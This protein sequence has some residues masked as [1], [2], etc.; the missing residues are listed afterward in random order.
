ME[1]GDMV[2]KATKTKGRPEAAAEEVVPP[3]KTQLILRLVR[4]KERGKVL[5]EMMDLCAESLKGVDIGVSK[6]TK[7]LAAMGL[8]RRIPPAKG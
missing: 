3:T 4:L 6:T 7:M 8:K 5:N 2:K 1:V